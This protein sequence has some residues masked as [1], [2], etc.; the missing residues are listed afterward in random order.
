MKECKT[1]G[2]G[3]YHWTPTITDHNDP[4][5]EKPGS[6]LIWMTLIRPILKYAL[7]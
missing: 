3:S 7:I 6:S 1:D 4:V 5:Q 2:T